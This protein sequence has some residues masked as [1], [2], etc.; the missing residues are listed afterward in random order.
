[1]DPAALN[2]Y[3][4]IER[5]PT[6]LVQGLYIFGI[7]SWLLVVH[8]FWYAIILDPFYRYFVG[9]ILLFLTVYY[10]SSFGL[11]LF[12]RRFDLE[13][14]FSLVKRYWSGIEELPSLD[15]F[16]PIC[17]EDDAI[18]RKT[19]DSVSRLNYANK[20][21]YVLDDSKERCD[22]HALMAKEYG[23]SY[24]SRP[25]KGEMKKAG[26]L[27]YGF[28]RSTGEFIAIFDA[29]FAPHPDFI[30]EL[31]PYM[32][33]PKVG[34][35]QSPQYFEATDRVHKRSLLEYGAAYVQEDFYRVIQV[36]RD[37]LGGALCCGSNAIYRRS[38]LDTIGGP[39]QVRYSEDSR[40]G[41]ALVGKGWLMRYV[42]IILAV[43]LCPDSAY[44]YFHQQHR[45]C[46][47][48]MELLTTK[49]EFWTAPMPLKARICYISGF[50]YYLQYPLAILMSFQLF[51]TLF[52]Y[53]AYISLSGVVQFLPF[54]IFSFILLPLYH[55]SRFR[56]GSLSTAMM[57]TYAYTHA[58]ATVVF[59]RKSVGWVPANVKYSAYSAAF[60]QGTFLVATYLFIYSAGV[61]LAV[62]MGY[63]HIFEYRYYSVQFW[64]FWNIFFSS[65]VLWQL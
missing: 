21:I 37:R 47:G 10:V 42:P 26:N 6:W 13:K 8:G 12:Y 5:T 2:K 39:L 23:F 24:L 30:H 64:I 17:G 1:M 63:L 33:D 3:L 49:K 22:E 16:L 29:D 50:L 46:S 27:K 58:V 45:W 7:I 55:I 25:N 4:Y 15:I 52:F 61:A 32:S 54:M 44:S 11:N 38:A 18:L 62:R 35:V 56:I 53:N 28:E 43:G 65:V 34:I 20:K 19:W 60:A 40:T 36:A 57:Q 41:V 48:S 51:Y 59:L 31:L 14:H 9:P